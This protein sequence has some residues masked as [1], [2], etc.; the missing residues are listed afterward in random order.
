VY[1]VWFWIFCDCGYLCGIGVECFEDKEASESEKKYK[2]VG[3][4]EDAMFGYI[5]N[6][7]SV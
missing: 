5:M 2:H 4:F 1:Y 7:V 3:L 6:D